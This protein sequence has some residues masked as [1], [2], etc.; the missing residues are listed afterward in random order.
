MEG[1]RLTEGSR[2]E[3]GQEQLGSCYIASA[4]SDTTNH[5]CVFLPHPRTLKASPISQ[6]L[7]PKN[8]LDGLAHLTAK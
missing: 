6:F 3:Y 2:V 8:L 5:A 7:R 1:P 4:D